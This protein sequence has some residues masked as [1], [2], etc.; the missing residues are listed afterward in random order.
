MATNVTTPNLGLVVPTPGQEPGPAYAI[1]VSDALVKIDGHTHTGA[2]NSDG[3]MIPAA[4]LNFNADITAQNH[5]LTSL[6]STR[7]TN[8]SGA[9]LGVGDVG[10]VYERAGDLWYNNAAGVPIQLT[11]GPSVI[12]ALATSYA[13]LIIATNHTINPTDPQNFFGT[14]TTT[15]ILTLQLP[16]SSSVPPGRFYVVKDATGA[17]ATHNI[18]IARAGSDTIEGTAANYVLSVAHQ[19]LLFVNDGLGNWMLFAEGDLGVVNAA[20]NVTTAGHFMLSSRSVTRSLTPLFVND[21]TGTLTAGFEAIVV[22]NSKIAGQA[23]DL[24]HGSTLTTCTL[25]VLPLNPTP[26]AGQKI[27]ARIVKQSLATSTSTTLVTTTDPTTGASYG[28]VHA[29]STAAIVE[30]I[31][32]TLYVYSLRLIGETGTGASTCIWYGST[33]TVTVTGIDDGVS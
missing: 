6:R 32:R 30:V 5:N 10:C 16:A 7:F 25:T 29:F 4:G 15:A 14:D 3:A 9:L 18:T 11:A 12:S 13:I 33:R 20:G 8:Q 2:S 31:D 27:S 26:P 22:A 24:P 17:A 19:N 21:I 28:T 1:D 23:I